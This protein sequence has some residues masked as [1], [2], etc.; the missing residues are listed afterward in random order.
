MT[1]PSFYLK[2]AAFL[3]LILISSPYSMPTFHTDVLKACAEV[4]DSLAKDYAQ[5]NPRDF[6]LWNNKNI[7]AA[8]KSVY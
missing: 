4:Q 3:S 5:K 1:I 8:G 2:K 6:I 7:T